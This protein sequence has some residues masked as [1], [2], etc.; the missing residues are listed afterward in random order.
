MTESPRAPISL[1]SDD[2][3]FEL[4]H[5]ARRGKISREEIAIL[6]ELAWNYRNMAERTER[7]IHE[8]VKGMEHIKS[9]TL[10]N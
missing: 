1:Y 9:N 8:L 4:I 5:R 10:F 2:N 6:A 3:F 7:A